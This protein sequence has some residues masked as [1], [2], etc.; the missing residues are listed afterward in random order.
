M[1]KLLTIIAMAVFAIG[2]QAIPAKRGIWRTVKLEDGTS[3]RVELRGNEYM[4]Y[5]QNRVGPTG[6]EPKV[7]TAL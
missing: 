6:Q 4:H 1:K 3:L 2:M 7:P 5:W